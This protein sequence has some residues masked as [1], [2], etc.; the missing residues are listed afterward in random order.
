VFERS[1]GSG[2]WWIQYFDSGRR[3]RE[4][5]GRRGDA[6]TL[7]GVRKAEIQAGK[8]LPQNM[9]RGGIKFQVLADEILMYSANHHK[10]TRNV[11]SRISQILPEFG[12]R[13]AASILPAEIDSWIVAN[14][15]SAGTANR[16]RAVFSLIYREALR[17][18]KVASNSAR[19]VRQRH[20]GNG[21]I[22]YLLDGQ[23]QRLREVIVRE[24]P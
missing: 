3:H 7:Y 10:D 22:R 8:K 11:Q 5:V 21:R 19:L 6:I 13:E 12:E 18:G 17:N 23:E 20:E 2:T 24:Y 15:K 4:K 16:Y 9:R 1:K 14:T